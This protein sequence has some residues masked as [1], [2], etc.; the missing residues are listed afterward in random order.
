MNENY[1]HNIVVKTSSFDILS[2][3]SE[4]YNFMGDR[5][6]FTFEKLIAKEELKLFKY[7]LSLLDSTYF[8]IKMYSR[9]QSKLDF[10][11][12][13]SPSTN[14]DQF[15]IRCVEMNKLI[16]EHMQLIK[17]QSIDYN[18]LNLYGDRI[19][20]FYPDNKDLVIYEPSIEGR[21]FKVI[22]LKDLNNIIPYDTSNLISAIENGDTN[23]EFIFRENTNNQEVIQVKGISIYNDGVFVKATGFIHKDTRTITNSNITPQMDSLTGTLTKNEILNFAVKKIDVDKCEGIAIAIIDV[24]YFKNVNDT[25]GHLKGDEVLRSIADI[26]KQQVGNYGLVGRFGGDEFFVLF[27]NG[28]D[29]DKIREILRSMKNIVNAKYAPNDKGNPII[30]LSIGCACYPKDAHNYKDLFIIA[31][32][33]LYVAKDLGRNRYVIYTPD[34]LKSLDEIKKDLS[35]KHDSISVSEGRTNLILSDVLC[36]LI[37][38][39]TDDYEININ[40]VI[41]DFSYIQDFQ[42]IILYDEQANPISIASTYNFDRQLITQNS[43]YVLDKKLNN[44]YENDVIIINNISILNNHAPDT[45]EP[46]K[47]Q[48]VKAFIHIRFKDKLNHKYV[49]SIEATNI[50]IT[51]DINNIHNYRLM[52]KLCSKVIN[53][54]GL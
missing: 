33:C 38:D 11:M 3:D 10:I 44:L 16:D 13:L 22:S 7:K 52:G 20:V 50:R 32:H 18:V 26:I 36:H 42:R 14:T 41:E 2:A 40:D 8:I 17:H 45:Y 31:D 19:F 35:T 23:F 49:L 5:L 24:D 9:T 29:N 21:S 37:S 15:I 39:F 54:F 4:F 25:L 27:Y 6:Y 34:R 51:W 1:I 30:S 48:G 43:Y 47:R 28:Y 53:K 12:N 46:L